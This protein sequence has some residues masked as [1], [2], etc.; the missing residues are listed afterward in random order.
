MPRA[1]R[2]ALARPLADF[3]RL[4]PARREAMARAFQTGSYT[5]QEIADHFGVHYS[6]VSRAVRRLETAKGAEGDL[7]IPLGDA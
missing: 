7:P 3:A 1:Q 2:R 4:Y 6:S 5:L